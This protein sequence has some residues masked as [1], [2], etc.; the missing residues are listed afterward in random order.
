M[1]DFSRRQILA[2]GGFIAT[3]PFINRISAFAEPQKAI[4]LALPTLIEP[5]NGETVTL[6]MAK[7]RHSFAPGHETLSAGINASYLGPTVRLKNR[8]DVKFTVQNRLGETTTLHWH[9]LFVPSPQDGGPHN[10]IEN[11]SDW[12]VAVHINQPSSFNWFHPHL[13]QHTAQQAHMGLSGLMIIDD[14]KDRERGLP[15]RYGRDDLPLVLQDRRV[16][17]GDHV[18][19]PDAM[20]LLH[21]FHGDKLIVNGMINPAA[22]IPAGIVRLRFL[23]GANARI[24]H[25]TFGDKRPFHAIASDGGYLARTARTETLQIAP[26]ERYEVLVD[27]SQGEKDVILY[28]SEQDDGSGDRLPLM[29]FVRA[30]DL[31]SDIK[32]IPQTLDGPGDNIAPSR[33]VRQRRFFMDD[34]MKEN[35]KIMMTPEN[36]HGGHDNMHN[37]MGMA[38][39]NHEM[40]H[41]SKSESQTGKHVTAITSGFAMAITDKTFDMNRIDV[42]TQ[43]GSYEL[44]ELSSS[45]DMMHPFHIHGASFRIVSQDSNLPQAWASGWK[46]TVLVNRKTEIL[47]HFNRNSE[48]E[49]PFMFHC[50]TLE[51]E[52][53]G[54]MGQFITV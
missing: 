15:V 7:G 53:L 48:R 27:F 51:H 54:M 5:E 39:D 21:G 46:D 4:P 49:K 40:M 12:N 28:T 52:D 18:Y 41:G 19:M 43:E 42:E 22:R 20:D 37:M 26:G 25:L 1:S 47:I 34:R 50:H 2:A 31:K 45:G 33:A 29:T 9:G 23:N 30:E 16:I 44:W 24:F 6:T 8:N 36:R 38:A 35:M 17:D 14:G 11:G 10:I 3:A 13:H 32:N